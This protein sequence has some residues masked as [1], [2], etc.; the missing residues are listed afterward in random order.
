MELF[1][2]ISRNSIKSILP[3]IRA[4][5]WK[6]KTYFVEFRQYFKTRLFFAFRDFWQGIVAASAVIT[7][8]SL[9]ISIAIP[10][11]TIEMN[12]ILLLIPFVITPVFVISL[13]FICSL[14]PRLRR[15]LDDYMGFSGRTQRERLSQLELQFKRDRNKYNKSFGNIENILRKHDEML[16]DLLKSKQKGRN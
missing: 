8:L 2:K 4:I 3:T 9:V 13:V 10:K 12:I 1:S 14:H 7:Y 5:K 6:V 15:F 11:K 16:Q